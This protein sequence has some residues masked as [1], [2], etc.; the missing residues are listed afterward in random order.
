MQVPA[1]LLEPVDRREAG[2]GI[3]AHQGVEETLNRLCVDQAEQIAD[4]G[5][6]QQVVARGQDLVED[7]FGVAHPAGGQASHQL[8]GARL[9]LPSVGRQDPFELAGDLLDAQPGEVEALD[10]GQ[11]GRPDLARIGRAE[12]EHDM[13]GRFLEGLEQDVPAFL[14]PLDLVDDVDLAG[15][16]R[17]GRPGPLEQLAHVVD[18]VVRGGVHLDHVERPALADRDARL[19]HVARLT[20]AHV[21]AVDRLGHDPGERGLARPARPDE[22]EAV[23]ESIRPD[24]IAKGGDHR[25]LADDL[26]EGLGTPAPIERPMRSRGRAGLRG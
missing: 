5:L 9:G 19:A 16:V 1:A 25:L 17:R 20:V 15:E 24:G 3:A 6:R 18:L 14:D 22:Q 11:D 7:R 10:P 8:D 2:Q 4:L 13:V 23:S 12:D 26:A 21:R